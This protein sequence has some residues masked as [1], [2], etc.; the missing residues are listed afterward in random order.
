MEYNVETLKSIPNMN[1]SLDK[2]DT[3]WEDRTN[4]LHLKQ[5]KQKVMRGQV[6]GGQFV[7]RGRM[8]IGAD[9]ASWRW[10]ILKATAELPF[11]GSIRA[12]RNWLPFVGASVQP[13]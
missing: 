8:E 11:P 12:A 9:H 7:S 1:D 5:K 4:T 3:K 10:A 6:R 13:Q 2:F